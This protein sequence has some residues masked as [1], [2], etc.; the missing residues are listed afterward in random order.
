MNL[1]INSLGQVEVQLLNNSQ[2]LGIIYCKQI[3]RRPRIATVPL[4]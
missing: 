3:W 2:K 1:S 4:N